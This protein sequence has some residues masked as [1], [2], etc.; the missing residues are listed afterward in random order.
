M[1]FARAANEDPKLKQALQKVVV[2]KADT[3]QGE[4]EKLAEQFHVHGN[5]TFVLMDDKGTVFD[6]F[7][8]YSQ[9]SDW[10]AQ[11]EGAMA[12]RTPIEEKA[13]RFERQPTA[14]L[15]AALGR[16]RAAEGNRKEAVRFYR[17]AQRLA[18]APN[19]WY[20]LQ[21]AL[22]QFRGIEDGDFTVEDLRA[23]ADSFFAIAPGDDLHRTQLGWVMAQVA[24][25]KKD[26]TLLAPYLEAAARSAERL[27]DPDAAEFRTELRAAKALVL[28]GNA[29]EA[30]RIKRDAMPAGWEA[31]A[32]KLNE[33]AWWCF[34]NRVNLEEAEKLARR[35]IELAKDDKQK[36]EILDTAA[37]IC[38][39]LGNCEES[40]T[41][42]TAAAKLDPDNEH[43]QKQLARFQELLAKQRQG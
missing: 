31:D 26:P 24:R 7:K 15:A 20:A 6:R 25:D 41:L 17:E 10:I 14:S 13:R 40:I 39:L 28:D 23:S 42:I 30:F 1:K 18:P 32:E 22:N 19:S 3:T 35:G 16:V 12:D 2:F 5:P 27:T 38:N 4:G 29:D 8:G 37:E 21:I 43:Y 9:P 36:G 33:L 11:F 34:E